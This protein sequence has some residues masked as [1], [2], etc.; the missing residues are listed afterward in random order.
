MKL[1]ILMKTFVVCMFG[2]SALYTQNS[3]GQFQ[4][5][6][7]NVIGP[8]GRIPINQSSRLEIINQGNLF[9]DLNLV[10]KTSVLY[11][12]NS[13]VYTFSVRVV[14]PSRRDPRFR[15]REYV[16]RGN[17]SQRVIIDE[18]KGVVFLKIKKM[19]G[20]VKKLII[21]RISV[22]NFPNRIRRI[23][24]IDNV[25]LAINLNYYNGGL[26]STV[27]FKGVPIFIMQTGYEIYQGRQNLNVLKFQ[28]NSSGTLF[29]N[30]SNQTIY[31]KSPQRQGV[32][33]KVRRVRK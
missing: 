10:N 6:G 32:W 15:G 7:G 12:G 24:L 33:T 31:Y 20:G 18:N 19:N 9:F 5:Q 23:N 27:G 21:S 1:R 25:N 26:S 13:P 2:F 14:K 11:M 28:G 16:L 4:T 17:T 3:Q 29:F 30:R 8:S 22:Q